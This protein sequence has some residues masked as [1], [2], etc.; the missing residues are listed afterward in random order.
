MLQDSSVNEECVV[1]KE[2]QLAHRDE[3]SQRSIWRDGREEGRGD[4]VITAGKV[5]RPELLS[6]VLEGVRTAHTVLQHLQRGIHSN[7][8]MILNPVKEKQEKRGR[9]HHGCATHCMRAGTEPRTVS[10]LCLT[11]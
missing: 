8:F 7:Q 10:C 11:Q 1:Q 2:A 3:L 4:I 9:Y 6:A 5:E